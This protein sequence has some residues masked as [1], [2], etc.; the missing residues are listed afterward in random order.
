MCGHISGEILTSRAV[1]S[2]APRWPGL[3]KLGCTGRV[4]LLGGEGCVCL[5]VGVP[6]S[7]ASHPSFEVLELGGETGEWA[8][9]ALGS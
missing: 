8:W 1:V 5:C 3:E 7:A 4:G 9:L 2:E 6:L